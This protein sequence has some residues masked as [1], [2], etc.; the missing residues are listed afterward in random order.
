LTG[1]GRAVLSATY[2][3]DEGPDI[4]QSSSPR[5]SL[6]RK[7]L[8]VWAIRLLALGLLIPVLLVS[9]DAMARL[10][11]RREPLLRWVVWALTASLPF[12]TCALFA[13]LLGALG[14]VAA[15]SGQLSARAL[16][17]DGSA[18]AALASTGLVL[19]L[20]MLA[21]PALVRRLALPLRPTAD[22][23]AVAVMLVLLVVALLTWIF[24]P[25]AC[26]LL[27]PALHLWLLAVRVGRE[28]G[29]SAP[30][31]RVLRLLVIIGGALPLL[32]LVVAY[33]R[34]LGLGPGG[35]VESIVI[36]LAG[37]QI[38]PFGALLWSA[39]LGCLLAVLVLAPQSVPSPRWS[40]P[41]EWVD[42]STR[43]PISY[44]GPGSLGGTESALRR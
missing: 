38:G 22:G 27:L 30:P 29:P 35:L 25:F 24:N 43:G 40:G 9:V 8:P 4:P 23:A 34:E 42:M 33:A 44:A 17:A 21:W 31:A 10:R 28:V 26:L 13:I 5:I 15:P 32:L 6:G 7:L 20:A 12:L 3:L 14:I 41:Q 2:A 39:G 19:V 36:A 1:F 37:G 11:R 18:P 16:S